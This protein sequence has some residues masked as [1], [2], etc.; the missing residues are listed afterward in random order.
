MK[1]YLFT[2]TIVLFGFSAH[3]TPTTDT[4]PTQK[5]QFEVSNTTDS[6]CCSTVDWRETKYSQY[7]L[8]E[9]KLKNTCSNKVRV[10]YK[11]RYDNGKLVP[12]TYELSPGQSVWLP[13]G[14]EKKMYEYDEK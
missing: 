10:S 14:Y 6:W 9:V 8:H 5:I 1:Q 11:Y 7:I 2:L 3:S 12:N 13:T 4:I